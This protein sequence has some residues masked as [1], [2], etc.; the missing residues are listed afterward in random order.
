VIAGSALTIRK[1]ATPAKITMIER[2]DPV[3]SPRKILSL[4]RVVLPRKVRSPC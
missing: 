2:A 4:A 3:L 1:I